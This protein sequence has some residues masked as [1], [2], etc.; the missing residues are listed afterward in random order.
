M[1]NKR[2]CWNW[3]TN[4]RNIKNIRSFEFIKPACYVKHNRKMGKAGPFCSRKC[5][6]VYGKNIQ[7]ARIAQLAGGN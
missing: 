4:E 7:I 2:T 6:G 1:K 5:A 3:Y